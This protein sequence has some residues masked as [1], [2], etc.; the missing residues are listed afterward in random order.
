MSQDKPKKNRP[1]YSG[2]EM[3]LN[4][5]PNGLDEGGEETTRRIAFQPSFEPTNTFEPPAFR[6]TTFA[7]TSKPTSRI[8]SS[9]K[10]AVVG[11][12]KLH[13]VPFLPEYH[14]LERTAVFVPRA[15]VP[16]VT[17]RISDVLRQRSIEAFYDDEKAKV[18]CTTLEGVDFRI[19]LYRGRAR[20]SHGIIVEVQRRFG[21]SNVFHSDTMA[22]LD[23]AEGKTP[24][25]PPP[26]SNMPLVC[27]ADDDFQADGTSPLK[28]VTKMLD[29]EGFD[30]FFLAFQT[31]QSLTDVS[32][33]GLST[34][35][36][37]AFELLRLDTD[38]DV[39]SK[40]FTFILDRKAED[41]MYKLRSLA[42]IILANSVQS[43]DGKIHE[44]LQEQLTPVL[45][46]ELRN[47]EKNPRNAVQAARII[48]YLPRQEQSVIEVY[49]A[50]EFAMKT[51]EVRLAALQHQAERS[52]R[53][54]G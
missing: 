21:T 44:I 40:V 48:E 28:M 2:N 45:I 11:I 37:V 35:R 29:H 17:M 39:G 22:I 10:K 53:K 41:D 18:T 25:P 12:W 50:L 54:Y 42:M 15:I 47:A 3:P 16:D 52:M 4:V 9:P 30:S 24:C 34:A 49:G 20:F 19:R 32:K 33:M 8:Q 31:L 26:S 27:D 43:V 38:S 5:N 23:A 14:P 6:E 13:D 1:T 36:A 51:G 7:G 46:K